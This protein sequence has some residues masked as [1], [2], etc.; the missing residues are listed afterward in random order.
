MFRTP[1]TYAT[2][3]SFAELI[4]VHEGRAGWLFLVGGQNRPLS[5]YG[6]SPGRL[7]RLWR[8]A[9]LVRSRERRCRALGARYL[10]LVV[11][12][13]L[14]IYPEMAPAL[15][16]SAERSP[17]LALGRM[18]RASSAWLDASRALRAGK[19]EGDMFLRT[20]T[21]WT[22]EGCFKVYLEL[23]SAAGVSHPIELRSRGSAEQEIVGDLGQKFDPPRG[24]LARRYRIALHA[25]RTYVN[26]LLAAY[27]ANGRPFALHRGAHVIYCNESPD[28]DPRRVVV[29]GDSYAHFEPFML[30]GMLAETF[31]ELHFVWSASVDWAYVERSRPDLVLGEIAERFMSRV[32]SDSYDM[33]AFANR[34]LARAGL[35]TQPASETGRTGA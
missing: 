9:R 31:R 30:T 1:D 20:D 25:K 11:P 8:W 33:E 22:L 24:E 23:C 35:A 28:A 14:S 7:W 26:A 13:K 15:A 3:A 32:P 17:V 19:A 34:Q 27:E 10:H 4:K 18:L 12:E 29:F 2:P 5:A 16:I 21:H 6:R